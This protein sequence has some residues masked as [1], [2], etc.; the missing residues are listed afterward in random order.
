MSVRETLISNKVDS[1]E[2]E[3]APEND[4]YPEDDFDNRMGSQI[5]RKRRELCDIR[6]HETSKTGSILFKFLT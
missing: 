6:P 2:L 4:D 3:H 5:L 1:R